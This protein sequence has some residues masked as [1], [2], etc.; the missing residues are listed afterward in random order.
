[1]V[2]ALV[3][4]SS[5]SKGP[6]RPEPRPDTGG[7]AAAVADAPTEA[8]CDT[9]LVHTIKL[10]VAERPADQQIGEDEQASVRTNVRAQFMPECRAMTRARFA[11]A[12]DAPNTNAMKACD[13]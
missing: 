13:E 5:P 2:V 9:L 1:M 6:E 11:C 7:S 3:A 4:C 12:L 8:E 10:A